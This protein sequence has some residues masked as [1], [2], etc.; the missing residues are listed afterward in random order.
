MWQDR[1]ACHGANPDDFIEQPVPVRLVARTCHGCDVKYHCRLM[2]LLEEFGVWGNTTPRN[3]I[4]MRKLLGVSQNS[5]TFD[6]MGRQS[7]LAD[8]HD[9]LVKANV[10]GMENA[11][12]I[13]GFPE[14]GIREFMADSPYDRLAQAAFVELAS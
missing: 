1:G 10:V 8:F 9:V 5:G 4:R 13:S 12:R 2:G 7:M 14:A 6:L 3:R 11:L